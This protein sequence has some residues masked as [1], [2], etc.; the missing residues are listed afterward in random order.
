M[1]TLQ[2]V[3]F[4]YTTL[5]DVPTEHL[6]ALQDLIQKF[7]TVGVKF[8]VF[9]NDSVDLTATLQRN[10]LP[11]VDLFLT[12]AD[13]GKKKGAKVWITRAAE[14][15]NCA[16]HQMLYIGDSFNDWTTAINSAVM[17]L[18][19][20]WSQARPL[21]KESLQVDTPDDIWVFA[22]HFLLQPPR[23][24]YKLDRQQSYLRCLLNA[25]TRLP[26]TIVSERASSEGFELKDIFTYKQDIQIGAWSGRDAL[27][28]HAITSLYLEGLIPQGTF[29]AAYP[30]HTPRT[31]DP[32]IDDW[33]RPAAKTFH[34]W[35]KEDLLVRAQAAPDTS[36]LRAT[37]RQATPEMQMS[38][39]HV[40]AD[41]RHKLSGRTV[42]LI[43]DFTTEGTSLEWGRRLLLAAGAARVVLLAVGK[44]G[45]R[46][47]L[48]H[49]GYVFNSEPSLDPFS[50]TE[51]S[52]DTLFTAHP[53]TLQADDDA[54]K[55]I[56]SSFEFMRN[57]AAYVTV[58]D[59]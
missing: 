44:F 1:S 14:V 13:V 20:R 11:E 54:A 55:R 10:A 43:D 59:V 17:Y 19:A 31:H 57:D 46:I 53:L 50:V 18:Q 38:T 30:S 25:R 39:V 33:F 29:F 58:V 48:T 23:W 26:G 51:E 34:G 5:K 56:G 6:S 22:T 7:R 21:G 15:M 8:A 12:A 40:K 49:S 27:M 45:R 47:P 2:V 3:I 24:Q 52:F 32:L 37:K 35:F 36:K 28:L 4:D 9:S 42:V 41:Y 16:P